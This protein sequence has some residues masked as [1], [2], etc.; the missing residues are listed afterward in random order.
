MQLQPLSTLTFA[1]LQ[2]LWRQRWPQFPLSEQLWHQQTALDPHFRPDLGATVWQEGRLLGVVSLKTPTQPLAWPSQNPKLGWISFLLVQPGLEGWVGAALLQHALQGLREQGLEQVRFGGDPSHLFPGAVLDD[3]AL[4]ETLES[5]GFVGGQIDHDY[6]RD[7]AGF[8][9]PLSAREALAKSGMKIAPCEVQQVGALLAFLWESFPGRWAYETE[10]RLAL[11]ATPADVVVLSDD[12]KV[13]GFAHVY[14][15]GSKRIGPGVYW[16][17]ALG[18]NAGGL[19]P[20]G[21]SAALRG[22]GLGMAL[23]AFALAHLEQLGARNTVIDWTTLADFYGK[24]GFE[25]WR[26]YQSFTRS[27]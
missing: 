6:M 12:Q 19:G 5:Q 9:V 24:L 26:G 1:H 11:E 16:R 17:E 8:V 23:L 21:V 13:W 15:Q 25:R 7:L 3:T 4:L 18:P 14:H 27:L 2:A 10:Q 22:Q 20:I